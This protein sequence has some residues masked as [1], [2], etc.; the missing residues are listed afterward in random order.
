MKFRFTCLLVVLCALLSIDS[1]AQKSTRILRGK[2]V[3]SSG[4]ALAGAV[5][6]VPSTKKGEV[7]NIDGEYAIA[8]PEGKRVPVEVS[9]MGMNTKKLF[10]EADQ[11]V[12][13]VTL[14]D[15]NQIEQSVITVGYGVV[16][17][18]SD[19]TGSAYQVNAED[20]K[21]L[22]KGNIAGMLSGIVPGLQVTESD[23]Y[24]RNRFSLRVRGD[25]S[26]SANCEPLWIV[27]DVPLYV[28]STTG[29]TVTGMSYSVSP[30]SFLNPE[31]IE[32]ITVLKDAAMTSIY[33]ANGSN[34]VILVTTK[35]GSND[36]Q[37]HLTAKI[38]QGFSKTDPTTLIKYCNK[39]QWLSLATEAFLGAG[40]TMDLF[41]YQDN[42][43]NSYSTTDTNWQ[44]VYLGPGQHSS[45]DLT[46]RN[47]AA[48]MSNYLDFSFF[49]EDF[50]VQGNNTK[51]FSVNERMSFDM[52]RKLRADLKLALSYNINDIFSLSSSMMKVIPI[53]SPYDEDGV[54]PRLY[55]WYIREL[56]TTEVV[57]R[58]FVYNDVPDR[59]FN[60][61]YQYGLTA[62]GSVNLKYNI[63]DGLTAST[64]LTL[65]NFSSMELMYDSSRTLDGISDSGLNGYSRRAAA[66]TNSW[67]HSSK[68]NFNKSI[69][70]NKMYALAG[71]EIHSRESHSFYATGQ[72]FS[73]DS[74]KEISYATDQT[75][76]GSSSAD[77]SRQLGYFANLSYTFDN[78]YVL[79]G[80]YRRDGYSA[81]STYH[82]WGHFGAAG[83][84]WNI[85]KERWWHSNHIDRLKIN[86]SYGL[87]GNSR[88]N[89]SSSYG[90]YTYGS[91]GNYGGAMGA[92]QSA[93]PNPGL[94]WETTY[95]FNLG[96]STALFNNRLNL[97]VDAYDNYTRDLLYSGRVSSIIESGSVTRNVGVMENKG[98]ELTV[99]VDIIK[100]PQRDWSV[101]FN[102][103][104]NRNIIQEL[105]K[106]MHTGFFDTVWVKGASKGAFWLSRWA[107]VDPTNGAPMWY[108][109]NGNLTYTFSYDNRVLLEQYDTQPDFYGAIVSDSRWGNLSLRVQCNY[110][111][112]GWALN[113]KY[114]DGYDILSSN[115]IVEELDHWR[116]PGDIAIN[117]IYQLNSSNNSSLGST[118]F[119]YNC[120]YFQIKNVALRYV[121]PDSF[122]RALKVNG[123]TVS[124]IG[125]NLYMF[126]AGMSKNRNSYK[127][128]TYQNG[129]TRAISAQIEIEF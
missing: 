61:N 73:N 90:T 17:K 45:I 75:K 63:L 64:L 93:V 96:V 8:L 91:S 5:V 121:M 44:Q 101:R 59:E 23:S 32:S 120:S 14:E 15:D 50:I 38:Q 33:G 35:K 78:R 106:D 56:G 1:F 69:G 30:I 77:N 71:Y 22:P 51:R 66:F 40:Y 67:T 37:A 95:K 117:P 81:F 28:G 46:I 83:V 11:T 116:K 12:L 127:T 68:L 108:D 10:V 6:Y 9:F 85:D 2:I 102:G 99:G 105:Y 41:P 21:T 84:A 107:G 111:L 119:L 7:A 4:E 87:D 114:Y 94:S 109:A 100:Q 97:Q 60:D 39:E 126:C 70:L 48:K 104:V 3:D 92:V 124:L 53:F 80:S 88:V 25:A 122:N 58:K 34:G 62:S 47:G 29:N 82:R 49:N 103:S 118:R 43:H 26:L 55:N 36:G 123:M 13:N 115:T 52:T 18:R 54:T 79:T 129:I 89:T 57:Q 86:A 19:I 31:D 20:I 16:Q 42:E 112:G 74:I 24:A 98:F 125:D 113:G 76:K 72:G 128:L 65:N 27:D 110:S